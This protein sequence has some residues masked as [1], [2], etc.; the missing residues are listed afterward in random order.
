MTNI[1]QTITSNKGVNGTKNGISKMSSELEKD[2]SNIYNNYNSES[3]LKDFTD[4]VKDSEKDLM[5]PLFC[6][7]EFDQN[8]KCQENKCVKSAIFKNV[9]NNK[10]ICWFHRF[11]QN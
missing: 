7:I 1:K 5:K 8:T 9:A 6:R 10:H 4:R 11:D 2:I 3:L